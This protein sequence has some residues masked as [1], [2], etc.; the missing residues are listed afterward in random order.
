[1][2][3]RRDRNEE[4]DQLYRRARLLAGDMWGYQDDS[5]FAGDAAVLQ[6]EREPAAERPA[7]EAQVWPC[8]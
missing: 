1:M 2:C 7:P 4:A 8:P 6:Q 3:E 5:E